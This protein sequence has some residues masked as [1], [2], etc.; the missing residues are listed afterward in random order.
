MFKASI[1]V[2]LTSIL[3]V[4]FF[5]FMQVSAQETKPVISLSE[6]VIVQGND[7]YLS[8]NISSEVPFAAL[9]I[10][11]LYD[12]T[13]IKA[14]SFDHGFLF[15]DINH[16]KDAFIDT[17]HQV[18][19]IFIS[20]TNI[21]TS[22]TLL[23]IRFSSLEDSELDLIILY[24]AINGMYDEN[25]DPIDVNTTNGSIKITEKT[26]PVKS[27]TYYQSMSQSQFKKDDTFTFE[28]YSYDLSS[29]AASNFELIFNHAHIE[30][31]EVDYGDVLKTPDVLI[32]VNANTRGLV[33]IAFAKTNGLFSAYPLLTFTFKVIA[34]IDVSST[35]TFQSK[36]TIDIDFLPI[37]TNI[38]TQSYTITK[39]VVEIMLPEIGLTSYLGTMKDDFYVDVILDDSLALSAGDFEI[40]FDHNILSYINHEIL[41]NEG[42]FI[43]NYRLNEQRL[44]FSFI[45]SEG[46]KASSVLRIYF[47]SKSTFPVFT[48]VQLSGS[49]LVDSNLN[50]VSVT[51][52]NANIDLRNGYDV[53]FKDYD[54][55]I[56][57]SSY[58]LS[59][60]MPVMPEVT[61]RLNTLFK[62]WNQTVSPITTDMTYVAEY[63]LNMSGITIQNKTT[64]YNG[65]TQS[66]DISGMPNGSRAEF[67]IS[68][69]KDVGTYFI[70]VSIYL[71]EVLQDEVIKK[72]VIE[73]KPIDI[74]LGSYE[75]TL[76]LDIP[77][78]TFTH[79]GLFEGDDL[80]LTYSVITNVVGTHELNAVSNNPNYIVNVNK[81]SLTVLDFPYAF[82]DVNQDQKISIVDAALIQ[83]HLAGVTTLNEG[84]LALSDVN[85]DLK[86]D[87]MDIAML[88]LIISGLIEDPNS[89]PR[90]LKRS[91]LNTFVAPPL[92]T[93]QLD[94]LSF[95]NETFIYNGTY[96]TI[97]VKGDLPAGVKRITYGNHLRKDVGSQFVIARFEVEEGYQKPSDLVAKISILKAALEIPVQNTKVTYDPLKTYHTLESIETRFKDIITPTYQSFSHHLPGTYFIKATYESLNYETK[98]VIHTLTIEKRQVALSISDILYS[99]TSHSIIIDAL[100]HMLIAFEDGPFEKVFTFDDLIHFHTYKL[101]VYKEESS[102]DQMSNIVEL[103][104]QTYDSIIEPLETLNQKSISLKD[105]EQLQELKERLKFIDPE[106][107]EASSIEL[108]K[109]ITSYNT[110]VENIVSEYESVEEIISIKLH[111]MTGLGLS[112]WLLLKRRFLS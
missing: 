99:K 51:Y 25:A 106:A 103:T 111:M 93:I 40:T 54:G 10:S 80:D 100:P 107:L 64:M 49:N 88:Q 74:T 92:Q 26:T 94:G 62:G 104:I 50:S 36:N 67:S 16:Q 47:K 63:T 41:T 83:L 95:E 89:Q 55:T 70:E 109:L 31:M 90:A 60:T 9:D 45:D 86:V 48:E 44:T 58:V 8:L 98:D 14:V 65:L 28:I 57:S 43:V 30:F 59:Q 87:I 12:A 3:S 1:H 6:Q 38:V 7:V 96:H 23:N 32:D 84:Q 82:G 72:L 81:G 71:D 39:K 102:F 91:K 13:N 76:Y 68:N 42:F 35:F 18:K 101:Y 78:F 77:E 11:I 85:K 17:E 2:I 66:L 20:D 27:S 46:M 112:I 97:E 53:V 73:P 52:S 5:A 15:N 61:P 110:L 105:L 79:N 75:M 24:V 56:I 33:L 69:T 108:D 19:Y 21:T 29:M 22:G 34:D 37:Q 4:C